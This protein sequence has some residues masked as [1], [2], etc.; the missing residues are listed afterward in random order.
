MR[1]SLGVVVAL[2]WLGGCSA[3]YAPVTVG[4]N[5]FAAL[6]LCPADGRLISP[7]GIYTVIECGYKPDEYA[8]AR[9]GEVL[10]VIGPEAYVSRIVQII[11]PEA[12]LS[13]VECH[14]QA[15]R[16]VGE[17]QALKTSFADQRARQRAEEFSARLAAAGAALQAMDPVITS[18][19]P[20]SRLGPSP[21][22]MTGF[23]TSQYT[24]GTMRTCVY[25]VGG[26]IAR[27]T[28]P[29]VE[30]CPLSW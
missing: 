29:M 9:N 11:C 6:E 23:L 20:N 17:R 12:E 19:P 18:P 28:I 27:R 13:P 3:S 24:Q 5:Q 2:F 1:K 21:S 26:E 8:I 15:M 16:F 4:I 7:L 22:M 10:E 25:N 30:M 14:E